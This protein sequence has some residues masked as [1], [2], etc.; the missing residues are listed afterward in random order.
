MILEF[1]DGTKISTQELAKML[2]EEGELGSVD[3]YKEKDGK[4]LRCAYGVLQ[5]CYLDKN[6]IC[7][8]RRKLTFNSILLLNKLSINMGRVWYPLMIPSKVPIR[9]GHYI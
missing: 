9:R 6:N 7:Q 3:L 8:S 1:M 2:L 4:S 5:D